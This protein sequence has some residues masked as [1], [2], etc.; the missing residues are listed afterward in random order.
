MTTKTDLFL[1]AAA[2][3]EDQQARF[4][5]TALRLAGFDLKVP[6][7]WLDR[8]L[9][10]W[11]DSLHYAVSQLDVPQC[12][13]PMERDIPLIAVDHAVRNSKELEPRD[14]EDMLHQM[15]VDLLRAHCN[16][17]PLEPIIQAVL[18]KAMIHAKV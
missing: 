4:S 17:E 15:R 1:H 13:L 14:S 16:G 12:V 9:D 3:I 6:H 2:L 5:C 8:V 18:D 7:R 11:L 10:R